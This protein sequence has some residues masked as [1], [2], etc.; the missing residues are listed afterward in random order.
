MEVGIPRG[1][2]VAVLVGE[3][4]NRTHVK[5]TA[6]K[7]GALTMSELKPVHT[8]RTSCRA[9]LGSGLT[10]I[11]S[12]GEQYLVNFVADIDHSLPKAPLDLVRCPGCGLLQLKHTV[13]PDLLFR[14][15]WYRSGVNTSMRVALEDV[16]RTG[17]QYHH[18]GTWL[19][20]GANDGY[21][22]SKVPPGFHRIACEPALNM[23]DELAEI[24]DVVIPDYFSAKHACLMGPTGVNFRTQGGCDVIT[25]AAM[26]YDLD[27]PGQFVSD[28]ATVLSPNGI[29]I[30]QLND[31]PT[32]MA[33]NGF[34]SLCHE[35]LC[36]YDIHSLNALYQR[37][38]LAIIGVTY[39]D[40]NGGSI[41]VTAERPLGRTRPAP[42]HDHK[43]VT[44]DDALRFAARTAKWKDR[45]TDL[46]TGT[47]AYDNGVWLYGAS[48]KGSV[49]LQYLDLDGAW[50]GIAD[51][52]PRKIGLKLAGP[53]VPI[54]SEDEMRA[55]KPKHV[56]V[57]PWAFRDEFIKRERP[58]LDAG[59]TLL[60]PLPNIEM[61]L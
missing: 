38:G 25:S 52:N 43:R 23:T 51:R 17:L 11:L 18:G 54:V 34:D 45:M 12:L 14:E 30:N 46:I 2:P 32:M 42:L 31:S 55:D 33:K 26:F 41:R 59:A 29:W 16:V 36:Y 48:T 56:M 40:V 60:F 35:H 27:D 37:H 7:D 24:A 21:L 50:K 57:L 49:M 58:L 22:L 8:E 9:C 1:S 28:I 61:V 44:E 6:S 15:F 5:A 20:I 39:N 53:W 4:M 19:D 13:S 10:P 3:K 47:L